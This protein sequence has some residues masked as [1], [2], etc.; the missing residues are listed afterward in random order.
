MQSAAEA[1][2]PVAAGNLCSHRA[3]R[4]VLSALW[5]LN[6]GEAMT[7]LPDLLSGVALTP[8]F[9]LLISKRLQEGASLYCAYHSPKNSYLSIITDKNLS[10]KIGLIR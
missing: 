8:S 4:P 3:V 10:D 5:S 1:E 9:T 7:R 2:A 6:Q